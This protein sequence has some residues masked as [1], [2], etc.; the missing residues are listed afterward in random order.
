MP[1]RKTAEESIRSASAVLSS[2]SSLLHSP[3]DAR[4]DPIVIINQ[5]LIPAAWSPSHP[6]N[7]PG[8]ASHPWAVPN[9]FAMA[10]QGCI[11]T[12][13]HNRRLLPFGSLRT[14][15]VRGSLSALIAILRA[16]VHENAQAAAASSSVVS[17]IERPVQLPV[18][19]PGLRSAHMK[20][21]GPPTSPSCPSCQGLGALGWV[22]VARAILAVRG[23]GRGF[24][25]W[26]HR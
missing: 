24:V 26:E 22:R 14:H 12:P 25:P 21:N 1:R 6:P 5:R 20:M 18:L 10:P 15:H 17:Q 23:A 13:V 8:V 7:P 19:V 16:H 11:A 9:V 4:P 3:I 2:S